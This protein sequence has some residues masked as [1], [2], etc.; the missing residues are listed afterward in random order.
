M[1]AGLSPEFDEGF[2]WLRPPVLNSLTRLAMVADAAEGRILAQGF[3]K[4][5][6]ATAPLD[7]QF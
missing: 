3:E 4:E 7:L 2:G 5:V 6:P 1:L